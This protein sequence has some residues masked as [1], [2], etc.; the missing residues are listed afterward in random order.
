MEGVYHTSSNDEPRETFPQA[1][2]ETALVFALGSER[3]VVTPSESALF[4]SVS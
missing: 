2:I 1:E 4:G 3:S